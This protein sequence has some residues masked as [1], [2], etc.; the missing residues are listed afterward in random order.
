MV[1]GRMILIHH[2]LRLANLTLWIDLQ[3]ALG[4]LGGLPGRDRDLLRVDAD[5]AQEA[6]RAS[7]AAHR[8]WAATPLDERKRRVSDALERLA[9]QRELLA[10]L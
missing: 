3:Q 9:Q 8:A 6:V 1:L 7:A 2:Q 10:L 4:E 5:A